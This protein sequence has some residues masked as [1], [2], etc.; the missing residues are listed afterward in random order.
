MLRLL[1]AAEFVV[2]SDLTLVECHRA[3]ERARSLDQISEDVFEGLR[4]LL[5]EVAASWIPL[6]LS[7]GIL[8]RARGSFPEEPLRALDAL[9]LATALHVAELFPE[10][11]LLTLDDRVRRSAQALELQILPPS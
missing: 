7:D 2:T 4:G 11:R 8:E 1:E 10:I 5:D 6:R 9:H 3:F